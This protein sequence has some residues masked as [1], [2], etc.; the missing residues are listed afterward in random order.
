MNSS[1]RTGSTS[2]NAL[3]HNL[4]LVNIFLGLQLFGLFGS[5]IVLICALIAS[6]KRYG[7]WYSF[8]ISWIISSVSYTLL[9]FGGQHDD[10][11]PTI[12][13]CM[14][15]ASLIYAAPPHTAAS[16]LGLVIQI[17]FSVHEGLGKKPFTGQRIWAHVFLLL[18]YILWLMIVIESLVIALMYPDTVKRSSSGMYCSS[19]IIIPGRISAALVSI[20]L[21][22]AIIVEALIIISIR[23]R[24]K[25][26]REQT[27]GSLVV[28]GTLFMIFG[29]I[30]AVLS[31]TFT[32]LV[33][34]GPHMNIVVSTIPI[35]AIIMFGTQRDLMGVLMFWRWRSAK[36]D[37]E[38]NPES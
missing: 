27:V 29:F 11:T 17:W 8:M 26:L 21:L 24:W 3:Q 34:K 1:I 7:S 6:V 37:V 32:F 10:P 19:R 25:A 15:Q 30:A 22:L 14:A 9:F 20:I 31:L 16:T 13:L 4:V 2:A 18:P 36:R 12:G 33:N 38:G 35:A 28:R 23:K 5:I